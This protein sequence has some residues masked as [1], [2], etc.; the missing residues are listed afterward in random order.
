MYKDTK[1]AGTFIFFSSVAAN[2][3]IKSNAV[4]T[5]WSK[6]N[7]AVD[8]TTTML[9]VELAAVTGYDAKMPAKPNALSPSPV[10]NL[11]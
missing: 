9:P 4:P 3:M 2:M 8:G 6:N 10:W 11:N 5:S 1:P 7:V